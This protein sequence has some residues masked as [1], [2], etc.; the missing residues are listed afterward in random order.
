M[1]KK[2]HIQEAYIN[3]KA[4]LDDYILN[5]NSK[6]KAFGN[7]DRNSL[8]LFDLG[9]KTINAKSF[10]IPNLINKIAYRFFRK[11]K[12]QRSFEYANILIQKGIGTPEPIAYYEFTTPLVFK[13]SYYISEQLDCEL[14][15]RELC[16]D[17]NYPDHEAILR[18]FTRFT[19]DLHEKEI[20]FLDHSPGNTLIKKVGDTYQ[21]F[22][23]DLNRMEFGP[24]DFEARMKNFGR[25]TTHKSMVKTM[26]DEYAKCLGESP[27]KVFVVMWGYTEAFQEKFQR[28]QKL[29]KK[30]KFW[31]K[32]D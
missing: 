7:Q 26:S 9:S 11:S 10:K 28:K 4:L 8:R 19:F 1:N 17:L 16:H 24:M 3:Q 2:E 23:V 18:G 6:G 12:A 30:L 31:K 20:N 32:H 25:L 13:N 5:F 21:Y 27:E 14:T 15:Y 29:K 22:L